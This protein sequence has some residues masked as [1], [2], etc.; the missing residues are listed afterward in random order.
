MTSI[1]SMA[2]KFLQRIM[3]GCPLVVASEFL[4]LGDYRRKENPY[5][6]LLCRT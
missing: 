5:E 2:I 6:L 4:T 1:S 3:K